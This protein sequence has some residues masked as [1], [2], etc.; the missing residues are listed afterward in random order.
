MT[1]YQ[2]RGEFE[3][4]ARHEELLREVNDLL[5]RAERDAVREI[6]GPSKPLVLIVGAPRSGTTLTLQW[7]AA[8]GQFGYPTNFLSRFFGAPYLGARIQELLTNP[9]FDYRGELRELYA[10][11]ID[12]SSQV[13]KTQGIL[14]PHEFFYFWRRFFPVD[15]AQKL[16]DEALAASDPEGFA[17]VWASLEQQAFFR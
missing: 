12:W 17:R 5:G 11:A 15:Q 8:S 4:L 13:G 9:E 7:L 10:G 6:S 1:D 3:G 2:R 14:Q 16:S